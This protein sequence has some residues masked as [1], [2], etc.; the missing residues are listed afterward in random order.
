MTFRERLQ[1]EKTDTKETKKNKTSLA[2][3]VIPLKNQGRWDWQLFSLNAT[4]VL[5]VCKY[6]AFI[7]YFLPSLQP[8]F[9][10]NPT[11]YSQEKR[12]KT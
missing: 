5:V 4:L 8:K 11:T 3:L 9:G 12:K 7:V 2:F 10:R 1:I 6:G